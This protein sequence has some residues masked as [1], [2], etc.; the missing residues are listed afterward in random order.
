[1]DRTLLKD[2]VYLL[3]VHIPSSVDGA[4]VDS[5]SVPSIVDPAT[6]PPAS[7][8]ERKLIRQIEVCSLFTAN[9]TTS[10]FDFLLKT[11]KK[12]YFLFHYG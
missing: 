3:S 5:S 6:L 9:D 8:L 4:V 12:R 10:V 7:D 11:Q 2:S 1:M